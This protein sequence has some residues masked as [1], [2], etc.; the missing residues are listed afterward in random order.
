MTTV[1]V[2]GATGYAAAELVRLLDAH[3][4][5]QI[6]TLDEDFAIDSSAGD[7]ILL[8]NASWRSYAWRAQ[9][10]CWWRTRTANHPMCPSGAARLRSGRSNSPEPSYFTPLAGW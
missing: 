6:A 10:G 5:V 7:V 4:D 9:G 2:V 3:P 1:H 8:G